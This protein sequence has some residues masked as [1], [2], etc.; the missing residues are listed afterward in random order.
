MKRTKIFYFCVLS[1]SLASVLAVLVHTLTHGAVTAQHLALV[2][3][4]LGLTAVHLVLFSKYFIK[5]SMWVGALIPVA[6]F[7][8]TSR[9][10]I[11]YLALCFMLWLLYEDSKDLENARIFLAS[12]ES[13]LSASRAIE[14]AQRNPKLGK[15]VLARIDRARRTALRA[16]DPVKWAELVWLE[17]ALPGGLPISD[18]RADERSSASEG[19]SS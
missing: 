12:D 7:L 9:F 4:T 10:M 3:L 2:A 13:S 17:V 1:C 5:A 14:V 6:S 19:V 16:S 8:A 11:L 15:Q 18:P